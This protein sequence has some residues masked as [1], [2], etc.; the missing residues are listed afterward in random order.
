MINIIAL[1]LAGSIFALS[2]CSMTK[3]SSAVSSHANFTN[4]TIRMDASGML[5]IKYD[6]EDRAIASLPGEHTYEKYI[7]LAEGI[8]P[9]EEKRL[10]TAAGMFSKINKVYIVPFILQSRSGTSEQSVERIDPD[11][12][13][14]SCFDARLSQY[15]EGRDHFLPLEDKIE[16]EKCLG[17]LATE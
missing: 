9:G 3:V 14:Y 5:V 12:A 2:G 15:P 11:D 17:K 7:A 16:I 6:G 1:S 8:A 13:K 4:A 10:R